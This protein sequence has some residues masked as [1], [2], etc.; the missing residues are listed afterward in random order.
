M[1]HLRTVMLQAWPS[2]GESPLDPA[3]SPAELQ[4][5][6]FAPLHRHIRFPLRFFQPDGIK[7][8]FLFNPCCCKVTIVMTAPVASL[9]CRKL[10]DWRKFE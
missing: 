9:F 7:R 2:L 10:Y 3:P 4:L 8:R 1:C 5:G 6:H